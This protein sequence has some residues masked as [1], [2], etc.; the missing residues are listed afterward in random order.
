MI[1]DD[2]EIQEEESELLQ[3]SET[4]SLLA[5]TG[6]DV[7]D[8]FEETTLAPSQKF[9]IGVVT[10]VSFLL[11]S[12]A[13]FP[14]DS[15]LRDMLQ[16]PQSPVR[17]NFTSLDLN[18][19]SEDEITDLGFRAGNFTLN[20][21]RVE[22]GLSWLGL[23]RNDLKGVI[24]VPEGL[25]LQAGDLSITGKRANI[26][27]DLDKA[28]ELPASQWNGAIQL[29][30]QD[31][32]FASLPSG[33]PLPLSPEDLEVPAARINAS[34]TSGALSLERSSIQTNLF[35]ISIG[36]GGRIPGTLGS[37]VLDGR[38]CLRPVS[39]LQE[40]NPAIFGFYT[41]M[42]GTGGGELCFLLKGN[43][44]NPQF[45]PERSPTADAPEPDGSDDP[46]AVDEPNE[47]GPPDTGE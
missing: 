20:A 11:F 10:V 29:E 23:M 30:L 17:L 3:T 38:L 32:R 25:S 42:G 39:N 4:E 33:I 46:G 9:W 27:L 8:E 24:A 36:G 34:F 45:Q 5:D 35:N 28:R 31:V 41:A 43:L 18:L 44:S 22:S 21:N 13:F 15:L 6:P 47:E 26:I 14:L 16:N 37:M 19:F 12:I 40:E 1:A 2:R 7:E